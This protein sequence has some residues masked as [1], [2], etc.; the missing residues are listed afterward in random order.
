MTLTL[1]CRLSFAYI[2]HLGALS[3]PTSVVMR[4]VSDRERTVVI[5]DY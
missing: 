5:V 3:N 2:N 4:D 1:N